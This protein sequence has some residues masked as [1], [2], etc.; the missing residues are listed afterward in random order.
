MYKPIAITINSK[1]DFSYSNLFEGLL[2]GI[3]SNDFIK[4]TK[5]QK[6]LIFLMQHS[7]GMILRVRRWPIVQL[8]A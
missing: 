4:S 8:Q 1:R 6:I 5:E 3:G 7:L 2:L